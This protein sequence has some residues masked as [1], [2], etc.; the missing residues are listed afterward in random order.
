V[1][2][3][4][5]LLFT[6]LAGLTETGRAGIFNTAAEGVAGPSWRPHPH[7]FTE[8][9]YAYTSASAN[10]GSA[11]AG[12]TAYS[13]AHP[14]FYSLTLGLAMFVGRFPLLVAVLAIAGNMAKKRRVPAGAG[15]FPVDGALFV[16]LL[17]GVIVIVGAL[18]FFPALSLGPIVE[19]LSLR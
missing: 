9:L 10:N 4:S 1:P 8:L 6:A 19:H 12:L 17:V 3:F 7:G 15:S 11:F 18:T 16:G 2:A 5:I 13:A 14:I